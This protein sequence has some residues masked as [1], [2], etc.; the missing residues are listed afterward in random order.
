[1]KAVTAAGDSSD[2][3]EMERTTVLRIPETTPE[4]GAAPDREPGR[5]AG[6]EPGET[7]GADAEASAEPER[8]SEPGR[9]S[10]AEP[11]TGAGSEDDTGTE[12]AA[13]SAAPAEHGA[14]GEVEPSASGEAES[15]T[16]PESGAVQ[17]GPSGGGADVPDSAGRVVGAPDSSAT[18]ERRND[19]D[20]E[21][22]ADAEAGHPADR[23]DGAAPD[24]EASAGEA[25]DAGSVTDAGADT[26]AAP[27][28]E[29]DTDEGDG[30]RSG[31]ATAADTEAD[32]D[33]EAGH[34]P[35]P[36]AGEGTGADASTSTDAD[37]GAGA[38]ADADADASAD[39]SAGAGADEGTNAGASTST[40]TSIDAGAVGG[41]GADA[42]ASTS[43]STDGGEG[44]DGGAS[45]GT[46]TGTSTD[47]DTDTDAGAG[48][49]EGT[50]A[51]AGAKDGHPANADAEART[52]SVA[53]AEV[54]HRAGSGRGATPGAEAGLQGDPEAGP[55]AE[56]GAVAGA[57]P[58]TRRDAAPGAGATAGAGAGLR[59]D[60]GA[61]ASAGVAPGGE[62]GPAAEPQG[63]P[64]G[65]VGFGSTPA[66]GAAVGGEAGAAVP[67]L[68]LLASLTNT[69]PAPE[70]PR[71]TIVRRVKVWTPLLL[72]LGGAFV[73]AQMLRPLPAPVFVAA[74]PDHALDGQFTVP[75]PAKGQAAVRVSGSGDVGT[76][77]EQKPVPT[78]SVA[79]IMTAY[80]ILKSHPLRNK[81]DAGPDVQV[82]ARAAA[83]GNS[84]SESRV[85]GLTAGTKFSEQDML[86]MMMIP[87]ANNIARL[88]ARWDT[89]SSDETAF[90]AK[91]NAAAK[92]LGMKDTTYTDPS[93]LDAGTVSTAVDQ[94]KL[95]EAVMK[96]ETFRAIVA[97]PNA[98]IKGLPKPI[99]N[100]NGDLL[101]A[102]G[103]SIRG[104]K[105]GSSTPAGGTLVWAAYK[106]VGDETPLVL[107]T[108][109][110]QHVDG[111]DPF[112]SNSL[113]LVLQNSR[114]VIEAVRGALASAPVVRKGQQVGYVDDGL[115]GR[116]PL[117]ATKDLNMVG[118]PGQRLR[119]SLTA[120][121]AGTPRTAKDGTEVGVLTVGDGAGAKSVPVAVRGDLAEPSF[122][123]RLTRLG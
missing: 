7:S 121:S 56:G 15:R 72:L 34:E 74:E 13:A 110:D 94:L 62:D 73:G 47:A 48:A 46:S 116:T 26:E 122:K 71:R 41:E 114:K 42:G 50:D 111:P 123:A 5:E 119:L 96:D 11:N 67:P 88:L 44:T 92:E 36:D 117:V 57:A 105:T 25:A 93:G 60:R 59:G 29:A 100:N 31:P 52:K 112:A 120:G 82:D 49:G 78:A 80:V 91:M 104:I 63:R 22:D 77:G 84:D 85:E 65:P 102:T 35:G 89:G 3:E 37:A 12:D 45:T 109:M 68:E 38:G 69:A 75:W 113:A 19:G 107:G 79:K 30:H 83:E 24:R 118:V 66:G 10:G 17:A 33:T 23:A 97:M 28:A 108:M 81:N 101:T 55:G 21:A 103:L 40:G 14:E 86:K 64:G 16:E 76:F 51:G 43:T 9:E 90:V 53:D 20:T 115:G 27:A 58:R 18:A 4:P 61:G 8:A 95:A 1:M 2:G 87:S 6:T 106:S 98:T 54:S 39:A 99:Y 70:T 32:A